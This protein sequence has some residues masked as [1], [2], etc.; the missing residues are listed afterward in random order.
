MILRTYFLHKEKIGTFRILELS[1][2]QM[3]THP[4]K[5]WFCTQSPMHSPRF[6]L[7]VTSCNFPL[8]AAVWLHSVH[9]SIPEAQVIVR[10]L[11]L[12]RV[13]RSSVS[14]P[15]GGNYFMSIL[16]ASLY[17]FIIMFFFFNLSCVPN[18]IRCSLRQR[19]YI[20]PLLVLSWHYIIFQHIEYQLNLATHYIFYI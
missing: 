16:P 19:S 20:I 14:S 7:P 1:L 3:D 13:L 12:S 9:V 11:A 6:S 17:L 15:F 8:V 10:P 2:I 18:F 5:V 4:P